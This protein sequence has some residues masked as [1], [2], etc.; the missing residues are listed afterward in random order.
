LQTDRD[1]LP[2]QGGNPDETK[3]QL[4]FEVDAQGRATRVILHQNGLDQ[5]AMRIE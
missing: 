5:P 2:L 4:T 3:R 1:T